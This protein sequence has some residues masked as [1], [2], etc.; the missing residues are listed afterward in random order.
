MSE[1]AVTESKGSMIGAFG[2]MPGL[3]DFFRANVPADFVSVWDEWLQNRLME[4]KDALGEHWQ[5]RYMSAPIWRFTLSPGLA[6]KSGMIGVLMASVDRVGR[7]FPLTLTCAVEELEQP[8]LFHQ[9]QSALFEALEDAAF[10][11]LDE[12][13]DRD[14]LMMRLSQIADPIVIE[15]SR[16]IRQNEAIS[17]TTNTSPEAVLAQSAID[18]DFEFPSV[19]STSTPL[20]ARLLVCEALPKT[21]H[22]V[23]LFDIEG[24]A[25]VGTPA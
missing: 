14:A 6:G 9:S 18:G 1:V 2:K 13:L 4:A 12:D 7:Q 5:A 8:L 17:V 24:T 22:M 23:G 3:G 19:W 16:I 10:A 15:S 25:W 11:A 21:E 20:G